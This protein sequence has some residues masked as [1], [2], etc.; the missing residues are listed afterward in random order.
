VVV[1]DAM[2]WCLTSDELTVTLIVAPDPE[3]SVEPGESRLD[4]EGMQLTAFE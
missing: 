2:R 3:S 1:T 4:I